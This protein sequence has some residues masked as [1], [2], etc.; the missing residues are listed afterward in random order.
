MQLAGED[1]RNQRGRTEA[2]P[3]SGFTSAEVWGVETGR[4]PREAGVLTDVQVQVLVATNDYLEI[5]PGRM[6]VGMEG[7]GLPVLLTDLELPTAELVQALSDL[8]ELGLIEGVSVAEATH[9]IIVNGVTARGRQ[10][11]P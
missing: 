2:G 1:F 11:L 4:R 6:E 8:D 3:T 7:E 9:P 5:N 10:E